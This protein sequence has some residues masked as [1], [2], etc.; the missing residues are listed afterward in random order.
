MS[1]APLQKVLDELSGA[2]TTPLSEMRPMFGSEAYELIGYIRR[3]EIGIASP[4]LHRS[5]MER[6]AG[7][8]A[9][10]RQLL[11]V[12]RK[13]RADILAVV[14]DAVNAGERL[15]NTLRTTSEELELCRKAFTEQARQL[16]ELEADVRRT[17]EDRDDLSQARADLGTLLSNEKSA[18]LATQ[19]ALAGGVGRIAAERTRQMDKE[20]WGPAHD[21]THTDGQLSGAAACYAIAGNEAANGFTS[22]HPRPALWPWSR[23]WWKP[24]PDPI[25]NLEKAGAL[26]A[27]EIDRLLRARASVAQA[28]Q[29]RADAQKGTT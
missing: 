2:S 20:G 12:A 27:A 11:A 24:S 7:E 25:R 15:A 4:G 8:N 9:E 23:D 5:M 10:L 6:F 29:P 19:R 14:D 26:I 22:H 21:D 17:V 1:H 18:H 3:L 16:K 28:D 13:D